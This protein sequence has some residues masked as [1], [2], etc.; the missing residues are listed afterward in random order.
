MPDH[1]GVSNEF[2]LFIREGSHI[3]VRSQLLTLLSFASSRSIKVFNS[4]SFS[5]FN[6][7]LRLAWD[8]AASLIPKRPPISLSFAPLYFWQQ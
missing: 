4:R 1:G 3:G 5:A 6:T 8:T 7:N 2:K